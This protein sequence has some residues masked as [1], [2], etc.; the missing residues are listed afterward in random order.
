MPWIA[1]AIAALALGAGIAAWLGLRTPSRYFTAT[2]V[3][4]VAT[5]LRDVGLSFPKTHEGIE[6]Y[7]TLR[8][9]LY[10]DERGRVDRVEVLESTLPPS[11]RDRAVRAFAATPF[12]PATRKG[13]PVKSVKKVEVRFEAPLRE[14]NR[15]GG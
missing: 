14:L 5:P 7:G 13:R 4:H 9:D 15:E 11:F 8:M 6:Y 3:D 10:I 2:E 1:I 12:E